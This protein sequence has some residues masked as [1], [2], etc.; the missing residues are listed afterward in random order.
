MS[1]DS[2]PEGVWL[3]R[4]RDWQVM[5]PLERSAYVRGQ[6]NAFTD[7]FL[8][9]R[10]AFKTQAG[11]DAVFEAVRDLYDIEHDRA[12]VAGVL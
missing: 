3:R 11:I 12:V 10:E 7:V 9:F 1:I 4:N 2:S 5:T 8:A 6:L